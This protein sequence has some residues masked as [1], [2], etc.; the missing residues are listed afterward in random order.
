MYKLQPARTPVC[1]GHHPRRGSAASGLLKSNDDDDRPGNPVARGWI[2][3]SR[4]ADAGHDWVP[5]ETISARDETTGRDGTTARP[6]GMIAE[7]A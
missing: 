7:R 4:T 5:T 1:Q 2:T 3:R 6:A